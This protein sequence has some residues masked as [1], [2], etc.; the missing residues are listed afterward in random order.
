MSPTNLSSHSSGSYSYKNRIRRIHKNEEDQ[1]AQLSMIQRR[2]EKLNMIE[3][4][5]D[6][7]AG[8]MASDNFLTDLLDSGDE[9][10]GIVVNP[11]RY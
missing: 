7:G 4:Y 2:F 9:G 10:E 11:S 8:V 6:E 3:R 5:L 1:Q